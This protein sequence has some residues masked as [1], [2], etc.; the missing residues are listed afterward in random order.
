MN[1]VLRFLVRH[2]RATL[3]GIAVATGGFALFLPRIGFEADYSKMLPAGDP[4]VAQ[5]DRARDLFGSQSMFM[6]ALEAEEGGT[7]FDLPSLVK[8]YRITDEL[9]ILVDEGL[10]EEVISPA[11]VKV[12]AGSAAAI[13]VR[14]ILSQPPNTEE[15]VAR[16]REMV[17]AER[18][19]K[20]TLFAADGRAAVLVLR[21]T[22]ELEDREDAMGRVL[23]RLTDL[24]ARYGGPER[25]HISGDAAFLVHVNRYMRQ[26]LGLLLPV[27]VGVVVAVL[28]A[29][30]RTWRGVILPLSVVLV[31]LVWTMGLMGVVGAKL[32]M[33]STFLPVLLVA[34]GS[35][36]GIHVV[37]DHAE[38]AR[39][40]G[41]RGDLA[42]RVAHEMLLPV[43]GAALTT[44]A[45]FLTLQSSFLVPT[46]EF[47]LFAAF[48]TLA[49]FVLAMTMIPC[50]LA[51]AP[52]PRTRRAR[53][54]R[55]FDAAAARSAR[56]LARHPILTLIGAG[57]VLGAFLAG[58]PLL[59]VE[60]DVTKYFR[61]DS[62]VVQGL[63][64]VEHRFGG[65]QELSVV[66]DTG[67]RDGLKNPEVLRF[68]DRIQGFLAEQPEVGAT[69]S[70]AD[71]VKETY[72]TLRGDDPAAYAIP[73]TSRAV[74][75]TLLLYEM[76]GGEVT[77]NLATADFSQG[78]VTA[79]VRSVGLSGY[80]RLTEVLETFLAREKPDVLAY[81]VTGSPALYI[82]LSRKLIQ[83]QLVSL[84]TSLGAVGAIVSLLMLSVGA[85][86]LS[87]LPLI[88]AVA[89]NFGV[90]G[91]AGAYLD[92]ATI[93]IASLSVGIGVDYAVHFLTRYRRAR[94]GGLEHGPA[95]EETFRVTGKAILVN[96]LTLTLGFLVMLLSRFGALVTFGWLVSLTM[97]TSVIGALFILPAVLAWA[98][99]RA[100]APRGRRLLPSGKHPASASPQG[101]RATEGGSR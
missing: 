24:T 28:L 60:S 35:A 86:L 15:D 46:R 26:D 11:S 53:R 66:L 72:F 90:M 29:S 97:V 41:G 77:R 23:D 27:V 54:E 38:L 34:V 91:Y 96:A 92:M 44:A 69:S 45:G 73:P 31:A 43:A 75:Q 84:G 39:R 55:W 74:A 25:F 79:R 61:S 89:G 10:L 99:P 78:R 21:V 88:V 4:I 63:R 19:V 100:L 2:P 81:Y 70:L 85:G 40:G 50:L 18:M 36:Y 1:R 101:R 65:S 8:L 17:L 93:M 57:A 5:Y 14:P 87:L 71:L 6:F 13:T 82:Q 68:M 94:G 7:L 49:A 62:P 56:F 30:F 16:F 67:R 64:F 52:L 51:L 58:V 98:S 9:A 20:D 33:I 48:G 83:S 42:E 12:V 3:V 47:G 76:G 59:R 80:A 32:T 37:N 95:L 22:P